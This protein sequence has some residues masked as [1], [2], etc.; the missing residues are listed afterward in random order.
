[1]TDAM[2]TDVRSDNCNRRLRK[3]GFAKQFLVSIRNRTAEN[4][5]AGY[6]RQK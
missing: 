2:R 3:T 4:S 1:M 6:A 5:R